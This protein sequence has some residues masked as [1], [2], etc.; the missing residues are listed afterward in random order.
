MHGVLP[1]FEPYP[2]VSTC[3]VLALEVKEGQQH[4]SM[5]VAAAAKVVLLCDQSP[6]DASA[7]EAAGK[8]F[9]LPFEQA[10]RA[11]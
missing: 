3:P 5:L 9:E 11:A 1:I 10:W 2:V 7:R 6:R 8:T 4:S